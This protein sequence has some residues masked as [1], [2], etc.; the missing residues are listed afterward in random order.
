M[1]VCSELLNTEFNTDNVI[2]NPLQITN[3][4]SRYAVDYLPIKKAYKEFGSKK[5]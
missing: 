1:C 5:H 2:T 3:V 4:Y